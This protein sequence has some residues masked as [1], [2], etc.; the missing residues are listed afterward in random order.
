MFLSCLMAA[1]FFFLDFL[2]IYFLWARGT[3]MLSFTSSVESLIDLLYSLFFFC[4]YYHCDYMLRVFLW[5]LH[6][7]AT[8]SMRWLRGPVLPYW[9]WRIG[10]VWRQRTVGGARMMET[11]SLIGARFPRNFGGHRRHLCP[12]MNPKGKWRLD[13]HFRHNSFQYSIILIWKTGN[14]PLS[15]DWSRLKWVIHFQSFRVLI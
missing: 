9:L 3:Q 6:P 14:E 8:F 11:R 7:I 10:G 15:A 5:L 1:F 12:E 2:S 13:Q 4:C